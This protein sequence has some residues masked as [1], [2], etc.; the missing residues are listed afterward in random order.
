MSIIAAEKGENCGW[1]YFVGTER[2]AG[3]ALGL[4]STDD[5]REKVFTAGG[6]LERLGIGT[7][8]ETGGGLA[9]GMGIGRELVTPGYPNAEPLCMGKPKREEAEFGCRRLYPMLGGGEEER[10]GAGIP[11]ATN[12]IFN[13]CCCCCCCCC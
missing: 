6:E 3:E 5:M 12:A 10:K 7:R 4:W 1:T 13:N 8:L 2:S 9:K 11:F